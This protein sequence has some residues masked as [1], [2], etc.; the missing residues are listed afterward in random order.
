MS[1][2]LERRGFKAAVKAELAEVESAE[3]LLA[4][5]ATGDQDCASE[6]TIFIAA[7]SIR[8]VQDRS[9]WWKGRRSRS[10]ANSFA[11]ISQAATGEEF[12]ASPQDI[13]DRLNYQL[14]RCVDLS[15]EGRLTG[16]MKRFRREHLSEIWSI[17]DSRN[18]LSS[19]GV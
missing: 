10:K 19:S 6:I 15:L 5:Q 13:R 1:N 17:E 16:A 14:S 3:K 4:F 7:P 9:H 8:T 2:I 12:V 11:G 18:T